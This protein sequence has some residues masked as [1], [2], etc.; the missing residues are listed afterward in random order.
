MKCPSCGHAEAYMGFSS[1]DCPN[2]SCRYHTARTQAP[3]STPTFTPSPGPAGIS[4]GITGAQGI[5]GPAASPTGIAT[6]NLSVDIT[7]SVA[8]RSTVLVS[9]VAHGDPGVP[10]K[11]IELL[12]EVPGMLVPRICTLTGRHTYLIIGVDADGQTTY[13]TH[14]QCTLDGVQPTDNWTQT[15]RIFP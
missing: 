8:K 15:A 1:I 13:N 9:V 3:T 11:N 14:W 12:W 6:L 2:P 4:G 5:T 7:A 10:N